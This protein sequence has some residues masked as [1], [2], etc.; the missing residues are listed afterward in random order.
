VIP[1]KL[2]VAA[3]VSGL[4][5]LGD[6]VAM[7]ARALPL[8]RFSDGFNT[9]SLSGAV[10][11]MFLILF[12]IGWVFGNGLGKAG[13]VLRFAVPLTVPGVFA[14]VLLLLLLYGNTA[15]DGVLFVLT[16]LLGPFYLGWALG[17]ITGLRRKSAESQD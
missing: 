1:R 15:P 12:A 10:I 9:L 13:V 14:F 17:C 6:V 7:V 16:M 8:P 3:W 11:G 4:V 2:L 5:V